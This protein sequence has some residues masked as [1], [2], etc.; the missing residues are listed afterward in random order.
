MH[1]K[2]SAGNQDFSSFTMLSEVLLGFINIRWSL[3]DTIHNFF[4]LYLIM[5]KSF[6]YFSQIC[7]EKNPVCH[8]W[9]E[10]IQLWINLIFYTI[11]VTQSTNSLIF[12]QVW[13]FFI[14][15]ERKE[16]ISENTRR[17]ELGH[18][19]QALRSMLTLREKYVSI[20]HRN[21]YPRVF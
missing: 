8:F 6:I 7:S 10:D 3:F 14:M 2:F 4:F 5:N 11:H 20:K 17:Y 1:L 18:F 16:I 15:Y 21:S 19:T 12:F 9:M 13:F